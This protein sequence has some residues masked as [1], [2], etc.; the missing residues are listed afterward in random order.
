MAAFQE[1]LSLP[2]GTFGGR[3]V[4]PRTTL[5]GNHIPVPVREIPKVGLCL[6]GLGG[7]LVVLKRNGKLL[8]CVLNTL[9]FLV[10]GVHM[11]TRHRHIWIYSMFIS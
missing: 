7:L 9:F 1:D 11:C 8:G 5:R 2:L 10:G 3:K 4:K 6:N